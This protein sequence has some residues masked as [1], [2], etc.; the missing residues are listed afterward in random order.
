MICRFL[1]FLERG[2]R[3]SLVVEGDSEIP[4]KDLC[5]VLKKFVTESGQVSG[6]HI[7]YPCS[8]CCFSWR[9]KIHPLFYTA[10]TLVQNVMVSHLNCSSPLTGLPEPICPTAH[11]IILVPHFFHLYWLKPFHWLSRTFGIIS[12]GLSQTPLL[13]Q[14]SFYTGFFQFL[15]LWTYYSLC[16]RCALLGDGQLGV[17]GTREDTRRGMEK[18]SLLYSQVLERQS[19][20][21]PRRGHMGAIAKG[22]GSPKQVG[23]REWKPWASAFTGAGGAGEYTRK[24]VRGFHWHMWILLGNGQGRIRNGN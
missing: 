16:L 14:H 3:A 13:L 5:K 6:S 23:S 10:T 24:D 15:D 1:P 12:P 17:G 18:Q 7:L 20:H 8:F 19:H 4:R 9:S 22:V 11:M 21:R 2:L